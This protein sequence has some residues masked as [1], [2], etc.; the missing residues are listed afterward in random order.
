VTRRLTLLL[1][2]AT[3]ALGFACGA[4]F[5][6]GAPDWA[7]L[8]GSDLN[9]GT[10]GQLAGANNVYVGNY[11]GGPSASNFSGARVVRTATDSFF[12]F[13]HSAA[14]TNSMLLP[15]TS[16]GRPTSMTI[17]KADGQNVTPLIVSGTPGITGDLQSWQFGAVSRSAID[18]QGRLRIEGI[19]LETVLNHGKVALEAVL[20]DGS[21][22]VLVPIAR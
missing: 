1:A 17:G 4:A 13:E 12:E 9:A 16:D 11:Y 7:W 21:T 22:Q 14:A 3:A 6:E 10:I 20:P 19:V 5:A 8:L 15:E 18:A 2:A